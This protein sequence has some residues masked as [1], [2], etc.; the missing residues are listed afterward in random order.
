M[1][2][3]ENEDRDLAIRKVLLVRKILVAGDKDLESVALRNIKE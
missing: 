1:V 3:R 2:G